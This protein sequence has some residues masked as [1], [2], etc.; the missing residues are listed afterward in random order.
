MAEKFTLTTEYLGYVNKPELTNINP[1][2]IVAGSVNVF[3]NLDGSIGSRKGSSLVP[4]TVSAGTEGITA[5]MDWKTSRGDY[6][7]L[8]RY[9]TKLDAI[10][11]DA[12]GVFT[13]LRISST[14][15]AGT[16]RGS[17]ATVFDPT[18]VIDKA[19]IA[20][21][22]HQI[23]SWSGALVKVSGVTSNTM[24]VA[25]STW[26]AKG[27]PVSGT[28]VSEGVTYTYT[29][30]GDTATLTGVTPDPTDTL[31]EYA[32]SDTNTETLTA[33]DTDYEI[34]Y[35]GV[36]RNQVY[37][38]SETSRLVP[39]SSGID[40][41]LYTI[42]T[43]RAAGDPNEFLLDDNSKG[44][45][46]TKQ[47]MLMFGSQNTVMEVQYVLS[48]DQTKEAFNIDHVI[49]G[50]NQ[51]SLSA[52]GRVSF[53]GNI[54]YITRDKQM[55]VISI[56]TRKIE[57]LDENPSEIVQNDFDNF[58]W[59]DS[60]MLVWERHI[61]IVVPKENKMMLIDINQSIWQAPQVFVGIDLGSV[62]VGNNNEL[63]GHSYTT[64]VSYIL[65]DPN[66]N[67]DLGVKVPTKAIFAYNHFGDRSRNKDFNLYYQDGY[68]TSGGEITRTLAYDY[69]GAGGVNVSLF[70]GTETQF[71]Q[72]IENDAGI[73]GAPLGERDLAGGSTEVISEDKRFRYVDTMPALDFY[74]LLVT[75]EQEVVDAAWR[76]VAHGCDVSIN[77]NNSNDIL[78]E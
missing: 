8:V 76:L 14:L 64:N 58:D 18:L 24:T 19:L 39:V 4:T 57:S 1:A 21:G 65:F 54:Y 6:F 34:D 66:T 56:S 37:L 20:V 46:P 15:P 71:L 25:S 68:I 60:Q 74:E 16:S 70:K 62:S 53:E 67:S 40:Y 38:G 50:D 33:V 72:H 2:F 49:N 52:N 26:G 3:I 13:T 77:S 23:E 61:V 35:L 28:V 12:D 30:G 27:F 75:Y 10:F 41:T 9:G 11:K 63:I 42:P 51:G 5:R 17:M 44:F 36:Y 22:T 48:A 7:T 43:D 32:F 69:Q 59:N 55:G 31:E 45:M 73:G 78:R 29:G 47:S